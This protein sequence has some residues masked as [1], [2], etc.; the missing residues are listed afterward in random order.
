M[1]R[2]F[3]GRRVAA[4]VLAAVVLTAVIPPAAAYTL[5]RWRITRALTL[6]E[7]AAGPLAAEKEGLRAVAAGHAVVCGPGRMP[8]A[9]GSG[10]AWVSAPATAGRSF[11]A[12]WPPDPW[13]RCYLLNVARVLAGDGGL[14]ISGGPDG[15]IETAVDATTPAGDDIG[16]V[17]R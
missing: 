11:D 1:A 16:V 8:D 12:M 7:A 10:L 14:L 6:A 4:F 17:V 13:G 3:E 2:E 15:T 9:R 5:A